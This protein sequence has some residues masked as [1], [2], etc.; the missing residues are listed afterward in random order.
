M[1]VLKYLSYAVLSVATAGAL[2]LTHREVYKEAYN[3]GFEKGDYKGQQVAARKMLENIGEE[4]GVLCISADN[5]VYKLPRFRRVERTT[6]EG[7][8]DIS[9]ELKVDCGDGSSVINFKKVPLPL[10]RSFTL[11]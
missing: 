9:L 8:Q 4:I 2:Y 3:A 7:V 5:K 11:W 1:G 6:P 10:P